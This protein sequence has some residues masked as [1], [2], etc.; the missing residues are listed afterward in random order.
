MKK[1][2][3]L[4]LIFAIATSITIN[5]QTIALHSTSGVQI[6]KGNTALA[7]AYTAAQNGD[8]LYLSGNAFTPPAAFDKQLMIYGAGHYV[9]STIA[10]G[11]SFINGNVT[12]SENADLFYI[13]GVEIS[14]QFI[15]TNNH[16]INNVVVKRCKIND[17]FNVQGNLSNPSTNLSLIGN[18]FVGPVYLSNTQNVIL[19]NC[20]VQGNVAYAGGCLITN[21]IILFSPAYALHDVSNS[22]VNNNIFI[23]GGLSQGTGN[24]YNNNLLVDATPAYGTLPTVAGDYVGIPQ[25][26]IFINQTGYAF[27]YSHDYHLQSPATYLGTDVTQVGIYG[28]SFPYKEGAVPQNP[29]IQIKNIAPATDANGDLKIQIQVGAQED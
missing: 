12:L 8:T 14:G 4:T 22:Q 29:H 19:S 28:G 24:I 13:E 11:K 17:L 3:L 26:S 18:V 25:S 27:N 21:N 23:G 16:S 9:D 15:F 20:I 7:T 5:A 1:K 6:F 2:S 10:T